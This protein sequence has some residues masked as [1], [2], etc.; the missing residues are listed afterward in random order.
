MPGYFVAPNTEDDETYIR[1][2]QEIVLH[3]S[4]RI[5]VGGGAAGPVS[6][7]CKTDA[8]GEFVA[9]T[10]PEADRTFD[11][12]TVPDGHYILAA[13]NCHPTDV[14]IR[15]GAVPVRA[16]WVGLVAA[17]T[18]SEKN[19]LGHEWVRYSDPTPLPAGNAIEPRVNAPIHIALTSANRH[20]FWM[21]PMTRGGPTMTAI[22]EWREDNEGN[23][24]VAYLQEYA[25]FNAQGLNIGNLRDGPYGRGGLGTP[26]CWRQMR[27][28]AWLVTLINAGVRILYPD[29]RV[30]TIWGLRLPEG[31]P[32]PCVKQ[33]Y[34][35]PDVIR[36]RYEKIGD[37]NPAN[38][39]CAIQDRLDDDIAWIANTDAHHVIKYHI[40]TRQT[41]G[42]VGSPIGAMGHTTGGIGEAVLMRRPRGLDWGADGM[43]YVT[44]AWNHSI[45]KINPDTLEFT[46]LHRSVVNWDTYTAGGTTPVGDTKGTRFW[47]MTQAT[48]RAQFEA[49]G[50]NGVG[51]YHHPQQCGF[52]ST[53]TKLIFGCDHSRVLKE[54]DTVTGNVRMWAGLPVGTF[55]A[56]EDYR[57][58]GWMSVSVNAGG[59]GPMKD[60]VFYADWDI[61]SGVIY[62]R[63]PATGDAFWM[64]RVIVDAAPAQSGSRFGRNNRVWTMSYPWGGGWAR[65]GSALMIGDSGAENVLEMSLRKATDIDW[66]IAAVSAGMSAWRF[67]T[68][69]DGL[70]L[71]NRF[72]DIGFDQLGRTQFQDMARWTDAEIDAW[73]GALRPDFDAAT[74]ANVRTYIR[75]SQQPPLLSAGDVT[76]PALPTQDLATTIGVS[77]MYT[78]N[79]AGTAGPEPDITK[80][81]VYVAGGAA[82]EVNVTPGQP[83]AAQATHPTSGTVLVEHSFVDA[84][85]NEG[86]R[87]P[88]QVFIPDQNAPAAP[89]GDLVLTSVVWS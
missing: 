43:L 75:Y 58:T 5:A 63:T 2:S 60:A 48:I 69:P 14:V 80:A 76:P 56:S 8:A 57:H 21:R 7:L 32:V 42:I 4:T 86:A 16:G 47:G 34:T 12:A 59:I 82:I 70:C 51:S 50:V 10:W 1:N 3:G 25:R 65:D 9:A 66:P 67:A 17:N 87:R 49:D 37:G 73:I 38:P 45:G 64:Q 30:E 6:L 18:E 61:D 81:R 26:V 13:E 88:Q 44:Q 29:G 41:I 35:G 36:S 24:H 15:N 89:A 68:G 23:I 19:R 62:G 55:G 78:L 74:V 52:E 77:P 28:K 20:Q 72:G 39:W 11:T 31:K 54:F 46:E 22:K 40:P 53:G 27:S 85:G 33:G 83:F 79:F 71:G 84:A